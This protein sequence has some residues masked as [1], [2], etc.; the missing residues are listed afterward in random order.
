VFSDPRFELS[1]RTALGF[2]QEDGFK[3]DDDKDWPQ[4]AQ[5][6]ALDWPEMT[7]LSCYVTIPCARK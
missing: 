7:N 6:S 4:N 5:F 2:L 1:S 3:N